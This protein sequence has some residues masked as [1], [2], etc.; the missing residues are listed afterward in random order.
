LVI[1]EIASA[2]RAIAG[3]HDEAEESIPL[4]HKPLESPD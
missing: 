4:T 3:A 2:I 1:H